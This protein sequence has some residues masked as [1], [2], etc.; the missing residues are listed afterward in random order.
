MTGCNSMG[1]T[2][3]D[4]RGLLRQQPHVPRNLPQQGDHG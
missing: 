2:V 1:R 4:I 3:M